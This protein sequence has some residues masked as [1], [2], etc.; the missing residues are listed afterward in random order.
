MMRLW[1]FFSHL[2]ACALFAAP[3]PGN[4]EGLKARVGDAKL[5]ILLTCPSQGLRETDCIVGEMH[6]PE[7]DG[8]PWAVFAE[9]QW[10]SPETDTVFLTQSEVGNHD[11]AI[12]RMARFAGS[13]DLFD[14]VLEYRLTGPGRITKFLRL[15][16]KKDIRLDR[17]ALWVDAK[18]KPAKIAKTNLQDIALFYRAGHRGIF[19]SLDFPYSNIER[20]AD[21][22]RILYPPYELLKQGQAY[23]THSL[24]IGATRP[25]GIERY[26]QDTGEVEAMDA[27]IQKRYQPRFEGPMFL[28]SCI[29]NRY[30]SPRGNI[31]WYTYNDQPTL[32]YSPELLKK[33]MDLVAQLGMEYYQFFP[34]VFDWGPNDPSPEVVRDVMNHARKIGLHAG[35]YSNPS[36]LFCGHYNDHSNKLDRPDWLVHQAPGKPSP[37]VFCLGNSEYAGYY[38][39][40][41]VD[42]C[43]KYGFEQHCFDFL[44]IFPCHAANH[45]HPPGGESI[46][47]QVRG[48]VCALEAI[49]A[50]SPHMMTWSNSGVWQDLL[51]KLAWYNPNIYLTDPGIWTHW[52]GLNMTRLLDDARREQMV[53]LHYSYFL[54]YRF[55]SNYQ[56]FL[57][58]NSAVP[59]IRNYQFGALSSL[60]VTPNISLGEIRPW[61]DRLPPSQQEEVIGFYRKWTSFVKAHFDLWKQTFH[62]GDNPG[63]GSVEIYSHAAMNHGF[64]FIINPQ[65]WS[66]EVK[67]PLDASLGFEGSGMVEIAEIY[68]EEKLCLADFD[69]S[70]SLG[71]TLSL[72]ARAQQVR[73]LEVRPAPA[74]VTSPRLYGLPGTI[75]ET[76]DGYLVKTAGMQ[77]SKH[78]FAIALPEGAGAITS[79]SVRLDVP[80]QP[81][82]DFYETPLQP[83]RQ[84]GPTTW[85]EIQF[86]RGLPPTEIRQWRA[87]PE[88]LEAGLTKKWNIDFPEEP[89][90][91]FPLF[92][93][94]EGSLSYPLNATQLSSQGFGPLANFCGA[95][96]DNAFGETQ[97]TWI[98]LNTSSGGLVR[99]PEDAE[100]ES[101]TESFGASARQQLLRAKKN[102]WWLQSRFDLPFINTLGMEPPFED[103]VILVFPMISPAKIARIEAWINGVPLPVERYH[104]PRNRSLY[105]HW[106]DLVGSGARRGENSL[107]VYL[108]MK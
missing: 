94:E 22:M 41:I 32:N 59:D 70:V 30:T 1:C 49:N 3:A 103:H 36:G 104:Y 20:E 27:Y 54:P 19:A 21:A 46:Y 77:G 6:G 105:C 76:G 34:G 71:T 63:M 48:L 23:E 72:T 52:Q 80:K 92:E 38:T 91:Q 69:T 43:R 86:R 85:F 18:G 88:N 25:T 45:G 89:W 108:E 42:T 2:M 68:P 11:P 90:M 31:V 64:I 44:K 17:V 47:H 61:M 93:Q 7:L 96:V 55:F 81:P 24:T 95:Y 60:A 4:G 26:G 87:I 74:K 65:Y 67:I 101:P 51:P 12:L 53:S 100:A 62:I 66:R 28:S 8:Y 15:I 99:L 102:N 29:I 50:V 84:S 9:G 57:S 78:R 83:V 10:I 73:I 75:E 56:Y 37:G 107:I 35:D 33:D 106:A 79:A 14:W 39:A 97:E 98:E 58:L 40:M 16:P 5:S 13:G 82:R